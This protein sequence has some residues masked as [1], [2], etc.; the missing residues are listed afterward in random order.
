MST[1]HN[2]PLSEGETA[3]IGAVEA[4][5]DVIQN[6]GIASN[7]A[8]DQAFASRRDAYL[9]REMPKAAAMMNIVREFACDPD[10]AAEREKKY[11]S[12][13]VQEGSS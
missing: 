3:T 1:T 12:A 9:S 5:I 8:F 4:M 6:A 13:N 11:H 2:P 7:A 10:R